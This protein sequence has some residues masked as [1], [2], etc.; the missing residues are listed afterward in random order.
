M[1]QQPQARPRTSRA[2][3][4]V[5]VALACA[6]CSAGVLSA[7][8]CR[9]DRPAQREQPVDASLP[10]QTFARQWATDL[11]LRGDALENL[12][13]RADQ[14]YAYTGKGRVVALALDSGALQ[15]SRPVK[16]G[17][18]M[19]HPPVV[20]NEKVELRGDQGPTAAVTA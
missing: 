9:K 15:Y 19:L 3:R 14:V 4:S 1:N 11:K 2:V 16:G 18:T 20:L 7:G 12:H 5:L 6:A 10:L 13:V 17:R 8:G